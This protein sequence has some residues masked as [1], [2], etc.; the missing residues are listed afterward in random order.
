MKALLTK[1]LPVL[2]LAG[3]LSVSCG[4]GNNSSGGGSSTTSPVI[5]GLPGNTYGQGSAYTSIDQVRAAF[6][7]K[8]LAD[9]LTVGTEV[10]HMGPY[11]NGNYGSGG[12]NF[13]GGFCIQLFGWSAGDCGG[14]NG[15]SQQDLLLDQLDNGV[16]KKVTAA[17][18]DSVSFQEPTGASNASGYWQYTYNGAQTQ[19]Y[20]RN[21]VDYKEMLGLDIPAQNIIQSYVS[22]ATITMSN[23]QS[24]AGQV[25]EIVVGYNNY[26]QQQ[27]Q[28]VKRFVLSTNMPIFA[29]PIAVINGFSPVMYGYNGLTAQVNGYLAYLGNS[30]N[31]NAVQGV[32]QIVINQLH[33]VQGYG[34]LQAVQNITI[35]F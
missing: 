31:A 11:F 33:V 32:Q 17:A 30:Q 23:G 25:L 1:T 28:E 20:N 27:I 7:N 10:Y 24:V 2:V 4:K 34:Q 6:Q 22:P 3:A 15:S 12:I 16:F 9:G 35:G 26:G 5:T 8:T 29:N 18:A 21:A 13:Q 14:N 19:S